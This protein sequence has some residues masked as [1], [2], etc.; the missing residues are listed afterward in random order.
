V[1]DIQI[2]V[3][4]A[5]VFSIRGKVSAPPNTGVGTQFLTLHPKDSEPDYIRPDQVPVSAAGLFEFQ[6]V[7][8]GH[9]VILAGRAVGNRGMPPPLFGR[10]EVT[11]TGDVD[12]AVVPMGPGITAVGTIR[13]EGKKPAQWPIVTLE[14]VDGQNGSYVRGADSKGA[15]QF[16]QPVAPGLLL[17]RVDGLSP[18][19][20][21]KSV[22]YGGQDALLA[23]LDLTGRPSG[24]LD[25]VLSSNVA[26]L[27]GKVTN[28]KGDPAGGIV[29][30][31]WP[32]K[33]NLLDAVISAS[34]DRDGNFEIGDLAP[35]E[36]LVAGLEEIDPALGQAMDFLQRLPGQ[37]SVVLEEGGQGSVDVKLISRERI[38]A[39][40][41]KLR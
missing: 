15:F 25:I 3:R 37:A 24:S 10:A 12:G 4:R 14:A 33:P 22:T 5:R 36:Y 13:V 19:I 16:P 8:T 7:E 31:V 34:T 6:D 38:A 28:G 26:T 35:G 29:V 1:K 23:P 39:E 20:Y 11:V 18:G 40:V 27:S 32:R 41:A 30:S 9:Y 2:H 17:A 21:L